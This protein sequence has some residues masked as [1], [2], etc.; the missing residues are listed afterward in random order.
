MNRTVLKVMLWDR[1][2]GR[3]LWDTAR[4]TT[5]FVYNP[6]MIG[7]K[8]DVAP[9]VASVSSPLARLPIY[10]NEERI[11][12]NLPSFLADSL[13]DDWGNRLFEYWRSS[14]KIASGD[15]TPIEKL[16]FIGSRGMG[17]LEFVPEIESVSVI[18]RVEV[19]ALAD[20]ARRIFAQREEI[21]IMPDDSLSMQ[22]LIAVGTSAG[23]RQPKAIIAINS[24]SGEIRSGQTTPLAGFDYYVL[25]FGDPDRS[26]AELEMVYYELATLAGI[27]MMPCR[28]MEV[29]GQQHFL[30]KR[31]DRRANEKLHVQTLAALYPKATDYDHLLWVC[32]KMRLSEVASE[33]VFRRMVFNILSNNTDDHNKN[34]S[35]LMDST[36]KWSLAPAYDITYIFN[37]G[38]YLPQEDHCLSV[39]GKLTDI[40][41]QDVLTLAE[42]NG[43][44][45]PEGI[46]KEV[47]VALTQ[48]RPLAKKHGVK[49][50]WI[51]RIETTLN[52]HL[53]EW[54]LVNDRAK[55]Y[56]FEINGVKVTEVYLEEAYKGNYH[57]FATVEGN[58]KR[59]VIRRQ[60]QEYD[61]ISK[62][63]LSSL[64][65]ET[66]KTVLNRFVVPQ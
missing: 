55:R 38:G 6:Q 11:Y 20:L 53:A 64:L 13:P 43:I 29:E 12:Q 33:Q 16:S 5:Y 44:R 19:S 17:A 63:G 57:L 9:L 24:E 28:L 42:N 66:L 36:G 34:F 7:G 61:L 27:D 45:N 65:E 47:A 60:M 23:G 25:K 48:F 30:T 54:G 39:N 31:F 52:R 8:I 26:T 40:K 62:Q 32:R 22:S 35:F 58:P 15:I 21:S 4:R 37:Y 51:G 50:E 14:Q 41:K 3:L 2:I 18:S 56:F 59:F 49:Q 10:A 1:E 46:I